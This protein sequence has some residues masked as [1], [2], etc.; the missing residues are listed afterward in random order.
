MT[1]VFVVSDTHFTSHVDSYT[2]YI[3]AWNSVVAPT[4]L[5]I[6]LGDIFSFFTFVKL[7]G[8]Y[9]S[10]YLQIFSHLNGRKILVRGNH[11]PDPSDLRYTEYFDQVY[12]NGMAHFIEFP[13]IIFSHEPLNYR[14]AERFPRDTNITLNIHGHY[15]QYGPTTMMKL[16]RK[17]IR[18]RYGTLSR[19]PKLP[20][21]WDYFCVNW[22]PTSIQRILRTYKRFT[23]RPH[24]ADRPIGKRDV[25]NVIAYI[26]NRPTCRAVRYMRLPTPSGFKGVGLQYLG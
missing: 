26:Q 25:N 18:T 22:F 9:P 19:D 5:V 20:G 13:H 11:D 17:P 24:Y 23:A 8:E 14:A 21:P 4:D 12:P 6:H 10:S 15:H 7:N 3:D 16:P 1:K 2:R